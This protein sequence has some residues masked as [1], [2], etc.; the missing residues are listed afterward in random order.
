M[1]QTVSLYLRLPFKPVLLVC[2]CKVKSLLVLNIFM[3]EYLDKILSWKEIKL[4]LSVKLQTE[5][6]CFCLNQASLTKNIMQ[7]SSTFR[8]SG[9]IPK[10]KKSALINDYENII[11]YSKESEQREV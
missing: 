11:D 4:A 6:L 7:S 10:V 8:I 3:S 5:Y 1:K 9:P 2:F